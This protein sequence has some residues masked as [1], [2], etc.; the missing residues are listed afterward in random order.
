[1]SIGDIIVFN[2]IAMFL[3]I[4]DLKITDDELKGYPQIQKWMTKMYSDPAI[5]KLDQDMKTAA[6][7]YKKVIPTA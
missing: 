4:S 2:E 6:K 3:E 1:M 5:Q 7:S